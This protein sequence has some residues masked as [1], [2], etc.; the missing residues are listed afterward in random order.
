M[1]TMKLALKPRSNSPCLIVATHMA[2]SAI[3]KIER[4]QLS[5]RFPDLIKIITVIFIVKGS[6]MYTFR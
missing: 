3:K 6:L 1:P 5:N 2:R 4:I